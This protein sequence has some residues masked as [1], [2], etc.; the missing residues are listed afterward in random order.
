M[1]IY[2]DMPARSAFERLPRFPSSPRLPTEQPPSVDGRPSRSLRRLSPT[3]VRFSSFSPFLVSAVRSWRSD[4]SPLSL[5]F[6]TSPHSFVSHISANSS[7]IFHSRTLVQ[8]TRGEG[9]AGR[10]SQACPEPRRVAGH[11]P[12]TPFPA[13]LT[14]GSSCKSFA[15][16]SYEKQQ[17]WST[18]VVT[19]R[20]HPQPSRYGFG[21]WWNMA[22]ASI[23][24]RRSGRQSLAWI[25]VEAGRG[26]SPCWE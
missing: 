20:S 4:R 10:R 14:N 11:A 2:R 19:T 23:S 7:P 18:S 21:G 25:P 12:L 8:K 26:S 5:C 22:M 1:V 24:I 15:C 3:A 6:H 13:T 16:H 9:L 17:G